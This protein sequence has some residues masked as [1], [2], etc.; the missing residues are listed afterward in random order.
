MGEPIPM[1]AINK[2]TILSPNMVRGLAW[3]AW[4]FNISL[5]VAAITLFCLTA[6]DL[7]QVLNNASIVVAFAAFSVVGLLI[8]L[9]RPQNRIGW[10][11]LAVGIGTGT[12]AFCGGY[13]A[14]AQA[15]P[16]LP[17]VFATT[18]L[19][20]IVWPFNFTL[21]LVFLPLLFPN[22]RL[23]SSRWRIFVWLALILILLD[24]LTQV[25][26]DLHLEIF[27]PWL[28]MQDA[29]QDVLILVVIPAIAALI[30]MVLRFIRSRGNERQ[31]MKWLTYGCAIMLILAI[32]GILAN[33]T[34]E[35]SF[36][37]AIIC[38]P[39]SIGISILRNRLYDIDRLISRTLIYLLLTALLVLTYLALVFGLQFALQ[40]ITHNSPVP[41]VISTLAV[42]ALFQPLRRAIQNVI[43]RSFY[44]RRYNAEQVLA[45]FGTTLRNE[46]DLSQ[47]NE[48]LL[49]VVRE[50]MQPEH[51]SLWLCTPG[52]REEREVAE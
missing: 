21:L 52:R 32:G 37:A 25:F 13:T 10:L 46:L 1:R 27:E 2:R 40:G 36:A 43:D 44:R 4:I 19:G 35:F 20:D 3:A 5:L 24:S 49:E 29:N 28:K 15:H 41:I 23:L 33:D 14:Y 9:Q 22:G 47:L 39:L 45:S 16:T 6:Q 18:I 17:G 31:Q 38:L 7:F 51:V 50:T 26:I 34:T 30:S 12:T 42:A 8:T 11:F 48:R